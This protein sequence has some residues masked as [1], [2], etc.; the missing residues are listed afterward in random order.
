SKLVYV[1]VMNLSELIRGADAFRVSLVLAKTMYFDGSRAG[2]ALPQG[3]PPAPGLVL[4]WFEMLHGRWN[5]YAVSL[6]QWNY[7]AAMLLLFHAGLR[8]LVSRSLSLVGV[9]LLSAFPLFLTHAALAGYADLPMALY[10]TAAGIF[11]HRYAREGGANDLRLAIVFSLCLPAIK[12]EGVTYLPIA[13]FC[14]GA[15]V[16]VRRGLVRPAAIAGVATLAAA[17]GLAAIFLLEA[18]YGTEGPPVLAA[19]WGNLVPGNRM[20]EIAGPLVDHFFWGFNNWMLA[21]T[22]VAMAFP[23]LALR[24]GRGED[25]PLA[26]YGGALLATFAYLYGVGGA[27]LW[28][29]NGT[30]VNR[31]FLQILPILLYGVLVFAEPILDPDGAG[32]APPG[33][34][35]RRG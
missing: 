21:G 16:A 25:L 20:G 13:L 23:L 19:V 33:P 22:L 11:L 28:L 10:L 9:Y 24:A 29:V 26:L 7:Y 4:A 27:Y 6:A 12:L 14:M 17:L 31:T 35:A 8:R 30:V 15:A 3:Y 2:F 32:N 5:E 34:W 18:R 1:L